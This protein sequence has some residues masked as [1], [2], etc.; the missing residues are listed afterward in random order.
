MAKAAKAKTGIIDSSPL[1]NPFHPTGVYNAGGAATAASLAIAFF[2]RPSVMNF[3]STSAI[4]S[5]RNGQAPCG[6]PAVG[7]VAVKRWC[8]VNSCKGIESSPSVP[9]TSV[10]M[11]SSPFA[12][13]S[14][15]RSPHN[16]LGVLLRC[17]RGLLVL[18]FVTSP[19]GDGRL[20]TERRVIF[21]RFFRKNDTFMA[22][23]NATVSK[24]IQRVLNRE[25]N[26]LHPKSY[27]W[28]KSWDAL[29]TVRMG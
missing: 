9:A 18:S 10:G 8:P 5:S 23:R 14:R 20:T 25:S 4:E 17:S 7:A 28:R 26:K 12:T 22:S 2:S 15:H 13:S 3:P 1:L 29:H 16:V 6:D 21:Y 27:K 24:P 11:T 19:L